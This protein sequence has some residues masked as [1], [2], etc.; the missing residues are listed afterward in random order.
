MSYFQNFCSN[1]L[2]REALSY[3]I[4]NKIVATFQL[5]VYQSFQFNTEC[6]QSLFLHC[7]QTRHNV[8]AVCKLFETQ[9][10]M[11]T[12]VHLDLGNTRGPGHIK[13]IVQSNFISSHY[14]LVQLS[15]TKSCNVTHRCALNI[16]LLA[17]PQEVIQGRVIGEHGAQKIGPP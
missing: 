4:S 11:F 5:Y 7:N 2:I 15:L 1:S 8:S 3:S 17:P 14:G 10:C 6:S 13:P 9:K 12:L 16:T